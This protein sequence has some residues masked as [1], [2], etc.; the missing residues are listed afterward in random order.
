MT[1]TMCQKLEAKN[2][3]KQRA[4]KNNFSHSL[5]SYALFAKLCLKRIADITAINDC[6][7]AMFALPFSFKFQNESF[8][9]SR[10]YFQ[11]STS[12]KAQATKHKLQSTSY[13]AQATKHK[14]Q[15]TSYKAQ[16]T[17]HKLQSTSYK[18]QAAKHKLQTPNLTSDSN[19]QQYINFGSK[20]SISHFVFSSVARIDT[21][22][23]V[24]CK[25]LAGHNYLH[26]AAREFGRPS[27]KKDAF[28]GGR[29]FA[30]LSDLI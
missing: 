22:F 8:D 7:F 29:I 1:C 11:E 26:E 28:L 17:K 19:Q 27:F 21:L 18:A 10:S 15:S 4:N 13:K 16:A 12:Y 5:F 24:P 20:I 23:L 25:Y 30:R 2:H 9:E 14:L 6:K 3:C